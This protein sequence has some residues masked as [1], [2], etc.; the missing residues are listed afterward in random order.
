MEMYSFYGS[1]SSL[2]RMTQIQQ[3]YYK[4]LLPLQLI[5]H[6]LYAVVYKCEKVSFSPKF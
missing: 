5:L 6:D 3:D 1:I 2:N 4:K